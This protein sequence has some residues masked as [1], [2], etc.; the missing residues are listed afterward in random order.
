VGEDVFQ[1]GDQ[2]R[3]RNDPSVAGVVVGESKIINSRPFFRVHPSVGV[4]Q[5]LPASQLELVPAEVD[6]IADLR[7]R[8]WSG[9]ADLG[10]VLSHVRLTGKLADLIYSMES[11]NTVFHAYQFKPVIK[12]LNSATKGLLIADE[13]GLGKTIE[14]GLTWKELVARYDLKRLLVVCPKSLQQKWR[15]ELRQKF[16]VPAQ[17]DDAAGLLTALEE[18]SASDDGFAI[19]SSLSALRPPKGW[20]SDDASVKTPRARLARLLNERGGQDPLVDLV[21]FDEAHH[22]RNPETAQH[23]LA[24]LLVDVSDYRLL[25]S[26]TPINL[27]SGDLRALLKLLDP[28][29][30]QREV[31]FDQLQ[32]ENEPILAARQRVLDPRTSLEDVLASLEEL[33]SGRLLKT[34]KRLDLLRRQIA[35]RDQPDGPALR[36]DIA[37]RLEEMSMLGG[38]VNRTRR[39]DVNE[40]QVVRRASTYP[41]S[42]T[43]VER[44]FYDEATAVIEDYA[45]TLGLNERFLL[46]TAQRLIASSMAAAYAHWASRADDFGLDEDSDDEERPGP[47]VSRLA[48]IC[49]SPEQ[50]AA[51]RKAD[52][53][54]VILKAALSDVW[55]EAAEDRIIIFSSFRRTIDY[56][57]ERLSEQGIRVFTLH[58]SIDAD[59]N[60]VLEAFEATPGPSVL[61]TSEVGGEGLDLQ[62]CRVLINYDLPWNPMRVEQ[63]IGRIDRI[64]Q[65]AAT[66]RILNLICSDTI[67]ERIYGRLYDRLQ[68]I[69]RTIG[70]FEAILG[71]IIAELE[72]KLLDPKLTDEE[73]AAE[74]ERAAVAIQTKKI[75]QDQLE[76]EAPA[77]IAHGDM[78]L[79]RIRNAHEQQ[80]W[81][82]PQDLADYVADVLRSRF[83][84]SSLDRAP[85]R[86][87]AHDLRFCS[88][89][90][91]A[92]TD[93]LNRKARRY[94]TGLRNALQPRRIVFG[95]NPDPQE[96]KAVEVVAMGHPL[97]RFASELRGDAEGV[98]VKPAVGGMISAA[99]APPG[100][101]PGRYALVVQQ[102][103]TFGLTVQEKLVTAAA[104]VPSGDVLDSGLADALMSALVAEPFNPL[105][106]SDEE[107]AHAVA[108][109]EDVLLGR[110]LFEASFDFV[111]SEEAAHADK[112]ETR[113]AVLRQQR[114]AQRIRAE[115][116]IGLLRSE[117]RTRTVPMEEGKLR[118][119]LARMDQRLAE[120]DQARTFR[121]SIPQTL[122]V[123]IVEVG[124]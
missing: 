41:W 114:E 28:D 47:L 21:I 58:G 105:A 81:I 108:I 8:K 68:L 101:S 73:Q 36:A 74:V 116:R 37:A 79:N 3:L 4:D 86:G 45:L 115:D 1:D 6:P 53:K 17:V 78:I 64:G 100:V 90:H 56:L 122:G 55:R 94:P 25:L 24:Q 99:A 23:K 35:E 51:L 61:L 77:L 96:L 54:L 26:A 124:S 92:F 65:A 15:M 20:D 19:V 70:G 87:F 42:M 57:Q 83:P 12:L 31:S 44:E 60:E 107:V 39:R 88:D 72:R 80:K 113:L 48:E 67:E 118:L 85:T 7:A 10:R 103:S 18:M 63:R 111:A 40:I 112:H 93:F 43:A 110:V 82:Q 50:L 30:F 13:V 91:V 102:W 119:F 52:S 27:H 69:E 11:T 120:A 121:S 32:Q 62:F 76:D 14:A 59:R 123:A 95:R 117:G 33:E 49:R 38:I 89:A 75:Q 2:V 106:L 5:L 84:A 22:L 9:P 71:P 29:L 16:S 98:Q 46:A 66:V 104:S 34:T 109:A 97:V